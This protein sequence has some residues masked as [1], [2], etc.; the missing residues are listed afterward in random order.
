MSTLPSVRVD[1]VCVGTVV[2][3]GDET[4]AIAKVA[5]PGAISV[6]PEGLGGDARAEDGHNSPDNAIHH[7]PAEHVA[8]WRTVFPD[9]AALVEDAPFGENLSTRGC[10]ETD[11]CIG[12][13]FRLGSSVI[14]LT[15]GR[16]PCWKLNHRM[17]EPGLVKQIHA[18]GRIGWYYRV[19]EA[20]TVSA[21]DALVCIERPHAGW[22]VARGAALLFG[23]RPEGAALEELL[24]LPALGEAWTARATKRLAKRS[25][26]ASP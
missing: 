25:S 15:Q 23:A 22:T 17:G 5:Q 3:Y 7:Y 12:D 24:T 26:G 14:E 16:D 11:V 6:A 19:L 4:S 18:Q 13:R 9:N 10:V 2:P 1:R 21:G 20:G 8:H